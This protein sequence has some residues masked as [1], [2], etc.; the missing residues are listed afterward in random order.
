MPNSH[1]FSPIG[2]IW[3]HVQH[4]GKVHTDKAAITEPED[5]SNAHDGMKALQM[6]PAMK[7]PV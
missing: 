2:L 6:Q 5:S 4:Q 3:Q 7:V 1:I